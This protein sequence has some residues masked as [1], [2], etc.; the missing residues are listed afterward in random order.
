[1]VQSILSES[2]QRMKLGL[3]KH[4]ARVDRLDLFTG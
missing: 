1:V 3:G 2:G 4:G